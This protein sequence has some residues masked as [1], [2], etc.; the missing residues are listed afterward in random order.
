METG[1]LTPK[2]EDVVEAM[3]FT[4]NFGQPDGFGSV[5][6]VEVR[7]SGSAALTLMWRDD[8]TG[9]EMQWSVMLT[10]DQ[11]QALG[12]FIGRYQPRLWERVLEPAP[13]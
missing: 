2:A 7:Q 11:R 4:G 5:L 3:R 9:N 1:S 6:K 12:Q 10:D 8:A 13:F